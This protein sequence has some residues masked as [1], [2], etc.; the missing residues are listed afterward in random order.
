MWLEQ[1]EAVDPNQDKRTF[2]CP[3]CKHMLSEAV[4]Y[5]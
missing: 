2:E 3:Q 4:K 1:I 5:R